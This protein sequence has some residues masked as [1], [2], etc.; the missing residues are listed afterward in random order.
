MHNKVRSLFV[1]PGHFYSPIV[2]VDEVSESFGC[3]SNLS[4]LPG[5]DISREAQI[6]VWRKLLPYLKDIPFPEEKS[7]G[8]RYFFNNP[9]FSYGDGSILYAMLRYYRPKRLVEVGSGYSSACA[10]DTIDRYLGEEVDVTFV[11]P[12]PDLLLRLL[13]AG[14]E[15]RFQIHA[16]TVQ[17]ADMAIFECLNK[18]DFLFIDSTHIMKTGSDVCHELFNILPALQSGVI[19]HFHDIF[20]PFEY[21]RQWVLDENRSWN[22]LY[23]LRAFLMYND[24]FEVIFFNDFFVNNYRPIIQADY[25]RMLKNSG[26]SIWL[27]KR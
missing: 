7:E 20:W 8:F 27:R 21:G 25:P 10:L 17:K 13:G 15:R 5:I 23:G 16:S 9:A 1:A 14:T 12:Y 3:L 2:N 26:G 22:E 18:G 11:E 4:E 19:I 6:T 24:V